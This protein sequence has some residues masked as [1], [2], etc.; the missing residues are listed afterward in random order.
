MSSFNNNQK[1]SDNYKSGITLLWVIKGVHHHPPFSSAILATA[2]ARWSPLI[3]SYIPHPSCTLH[4]IFTFL[5]ENYMWLF[6]GGI[7]LRVGG[8]LYAYP[9]PPP[10]ILWSCD[11]V[12]MRRP[13]DVNFGCDS[14]VEKSFLT[15]K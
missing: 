5:G 7:S 9:F 15:K 2:R 13:F 3:V 11:I 1:P 4:S 6:D 10:L 8:F 12:V 14:L